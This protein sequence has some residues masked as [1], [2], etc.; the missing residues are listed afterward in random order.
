V[1][2]IG[3]EADSLNGYVLIEFIPIGRL[4]FD[5]Q[6]PLH[7]GRVIKLD[8]PLQYPLSDQDAGVFTPLFRRLALGCNDLVE[9]RACWDPKLRRSCPS[10]YCVTL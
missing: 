3:D 6:A 5:N 10:E 2:V 8:F 1:I 7:S 4:G 9:V